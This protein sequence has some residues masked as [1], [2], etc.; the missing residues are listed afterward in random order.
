MKQTSNVAVS[1]IESDKKDV[2]ISNTID[3][4]IP[5]KAFQ[6]EAAIKSKSNIKAKAKDL[7]KYFNR[8]V[9][10]PLFY[11][12]SSSGH[13]A[14]GIYETKKVLAKSDFRLDASHFST[15]KDNKWID[16]KVIDCY[17]ASHADEWEENTMFL[18]TDDTIEI[19]GGNSVNTVRSFGKRIHK[20]SAHLPERLLLPY[21]YN[22][23]W[24]LLVVN[25]KNKTLCLLDPYANDDVEYERVVKAF[26]EF[27]IK[28]K[29]PS[30]FPSLKHVEWKRLHFAEERPIQPS[31]D[32]TNC[33]LLVMRYLEGIGKNENMDSTMN[34]SNYRRV[35]SRHLLIR[36]SNVINLCLH[37]FSSKDLTGS[38]QCDLC[39]RYC[40]LD[41]MHK[42]IQVT[43]DELE[44]KCNKTVRFKGKPPKNFHCRLCL[45]YRNNET[46]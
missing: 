19:I 36:S 6:E 16:G 22:S 14:V 32:G 23:H 25:I 4:N 9:K 24:R 39:K 26:K 41:C 13:V 1:L 17:T 8:F 31:N 18:T 33:G 44:G 35:V 5:I 27:I 21:V 11:Q 2:V 10:D 37:C 46:H 3:E 40:H 30:N 43:D 28:F 29:S 34:F 20:I 38:V 15:L 42:T 7:P 12:Q 45:K